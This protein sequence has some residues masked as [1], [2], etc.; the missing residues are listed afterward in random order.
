MSKSTRPKFNYYFVAL[1]RPGTGW[2]YVVKAVSESHAKRQATRKYGE[3]P[4]IVYQ[5][6]ADFKAKQVEKSEQE[7]Y[8]NMGATNFLL[9]LQAAGLLDSLAERLPNPRV[10]QA[11]E[12]FLEH[13]HQINPHLIKEIRQLI[14]KTH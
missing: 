4:S 2:S 12:T 9:A 3:V 1:D 5:V 8:N 11:I 13:H 7:R 6:S 10:V 14:G